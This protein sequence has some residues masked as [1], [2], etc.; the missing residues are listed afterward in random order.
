MR[1]LVCSAAL[2]LSLLLSLSVEASHY[3]WVIPAGGVDRAKVLDA[4]KGEHGVVRDESSGALL[5]ETPNVLVATADY[6][7]V[8]LAP[9]N[10]IGH[11]TK[12]FDPLDTK[13]GKAK[14][15]PAGRVLAL[16]QFRAL[17]RDEWLRDLQQRDVEL[18]T[19]FPHAAYLVRFDAKKERE[20]A[21]LSYVRSIVPWS[22]DLRFGPWP[23]EPKHQKRQARIVLFRPTAA[24][25]EDI[26]R[27]N[28]VMETGRSGEQTIV[29]LLASRKDLDLVADLGNVVAVE[30]YAEPQP[31]DESANLITA[32]LL[33]HE[34]YPPQYNE[35]L[36]R[37]GYR[38]SAVTVGVVDTGVDAL[39]PDLAGRVTD[40]LSGADPG[41]SSINHGT[42]TAGIVGGD[43]AHPADGEGFRLGQGAAPGASILNQ[44]RSKFGWSPAADPNCAGLSEFPCITKQT[45]TTAGT[46][47]QPGSIQ[48]NSWNNS[49]ATVPSPHT[50]ASSEQEFDRLV[51]DANPSNAQL[52]P[53]TVVFSAGN[54]GS[55]GM[56]RPH[57]GKNVITVGATAAMHGLSTY[58][59]ES[60]G[61]PL[62]LR[63]RNL[64]YCLTSWGNVQDGRIK[65]DVM[66]PG[67]AVASLKSPGERGVD[68]YHVVTS[69][70]SGSA[71]NVSGQAAILTETWMYRYRR[72]PSPAM[73]KAMLVNSADPL[74]REGDF[75]R[76]SPR[77]PASEPFPNRIEG[78]GLVNTRKHLEVT[79]VPVEYRDQESADILR[80][81]LQTRSFDYLV[82]SPDTPVY[83]T[84]VWTDKEGAIGANPALV[85]D[86]DLEV[87]LGRFLYRGNVLNGKR[88]IAGGTRDPRNNVENVFLESGPPGAR[89]SIRVRGTAVNGDGVPQ[90]DDPTDQDFALVIYNGCKPSSVFVPSPASV[91]ATLTRVQDKWEIGLT[92]KSSAGEKSIGTVWRAAKPDGP[93][94]YIGSSRIPSFA[95]TILQPGDY[96]YIVR[97]VEECA[98]SKDSAPVPV[99]VRF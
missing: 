30:P 20:L 18:I 95:D 63:D 40:V 24:E 82:G 99:F 76:S 9:L 51:R 89:M 5:V 37:L 50:Y 72:M 55:V 45:V 53:L 25:L 58:S 10:L 16:V 28:T 26:A 81:T 2:G 94:D 56:T 21:S 14:S 68:A 66:A 87:Q 79:A 60:C 3:A 7:V 86:L 42:W 57:T 69:G 59:D 97:T 93:F 39:H 77:V 12:T 83:I 46:N 92:W 96:Y 35:W 34:P 71:P 17:V 80:T 43:C 23:E 38:G 98:V 1:A 32:G 88:S 27:K 65:P 31:D 19:F 74:R 73:I 47:G 6:D 54:A 91:N 84:L 22:V 62:C 78:W 75:C 61:G 29:R 4:L 36:D 64:L 44:P 49:M 11:W 13:L 85:N 52:D 41:P 67:A 33:G 90:D 15:D 48:S 8:P 70:T